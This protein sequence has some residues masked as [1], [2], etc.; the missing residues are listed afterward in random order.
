MPRQA[1]LDI[2]DVTYHVFAKAKDSH[3]LFICN[4]DYDHFIS[5]LQTIFSDHGIQCYAWSLLPEHFYLLIRPE[6]A[7][8]KTTMRKLL[9]AYV[10]AYKQRHK[11][12]GKVFH[13]RYQSIICE[14]EPYLV[15]LICATHLRP[16]QAGLCNNINHLNN[17]P[18]SGH[19]SMT[20]NTG[21]E[22]DNA[23]TQIALKQFSENSVPSARKRY[24][25]KLDEMLDSNTF[26]FEGGG[27]MRSTGST[28]KDIWHTT[29]DEIA[30]YDSRILGSPEFVRQVLDTNQ[31][32]SEQTSDN[33][34]SIHH[35]I[36][37]VSNY[38]Q[39]SPDRLFEKNQKKSVS[40]ARC[41][42]C[43]IEINHLKRSGVVVGKMMKIQAFSAI[44]CARRGQKI[45]ESDEKLQKLIGFP[46]LD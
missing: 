25:Q 40:Q 16:I 14:D 4:E 24:L 36:E 30:Q 7:I 8:L 18:W 10:S 17:Y 22:I 35:L 34:I 1:R 23:A 9:T 15:P 38:Y 44:R 41:V 39:I 42:I 2:P 27:W 6:K 3:K 43:H 13:G 37:T 12:D 45:Y 29:D 11:T 46:L 5:L 26:N 20:G 19:Q 32:L 28:R 21:Y 31:I 33:Y